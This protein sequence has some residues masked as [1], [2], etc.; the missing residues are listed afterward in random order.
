MNPS[1]FNK[2]TQEFIFREAKQSGLP[3][4]YKGQDCEEFIKAAHD[5]GIELKDY[6]KRNYVYPPLEPDKTKF[7]DDENYRVRKESY[8]KFKA[9][10]DSNLADGT[11]EK[12]YEV[13]FFGKMSGETKYAYMVPEEATDEEAKAAINTKEKINESKQ[14]IQRYKEQAKQEG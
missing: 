12:V 13:C 5:A 8:D 1:C 14:M 6:T 7:T 9:I 10:F 2:K 3:C 11:T 4:I